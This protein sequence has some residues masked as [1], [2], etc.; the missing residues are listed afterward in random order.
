MQAEKILVLG[1]DGMDP[2]FT[3]YMLDNGEL[4]NIKKLIERGSCREDLVMLGGVPTITPPMWTTLATGANP[5][6]HGITCFWNQHPDKLD[7]LV[8][9]L[10]SRKCKAEQLWNVFAESGKKTM[11]W[12]WPGSSWPP[13][14]DSP[15]LSVVEGTQPPGIHNGI[16]SVDKQ[17]LLTASIEYD[18]IQKKGVAQGVAA[19]AGCVIEG[20]EIKENE[21]TGVT[22]VSANESVHYLFKHADGEAAAETLA[23][24]EQYSSPL[25]RPD[26]WS[27]EVPEDAKEFY[28]V[29]CNGLKQYP[30][31]ML[32]NNDGEYDTVVVYKNKKHAEA[33]LSV[34]KGEF[35]GEFIE[36]IVKADGSKV[37][38]ARQAS[39]IKM[40]KNG[41][42]IELWFS[43][44]LE[45]D[46]PPILWHP[47][48]LYQEIMDHVGFVPAT[49]SAA[50]DYPE[51]VENR[52]LPSWD[53][54]QKWQA[55]CLMYLIREKGYE[56]IFSHIHNIDAVGHHF[57]RYLKEREGHAVNAPERYQECIKE[58]YRQTDEYVGTFLPLL[59]EGWT[60]FVTSDHG[61]LSAL[62]DEMPLLGEGF[63]VNMGVMLQLGYTVLKQDTDGKYLKEIDW[64]KTTAVAPRGNHIY[65]NL[66][67]RNSTGIVDE[68][69]K[70][71]LETKIIDDLYAYRING[72]RVIKLAVRN[73]DAAI[74][75]MSGPECGDIIYFVE[76]GYNRLHGDSWATT[77]GYYHTS[78]SPIFIAA[79]QGIKKNCKTERAIHE[80]DFAPTIA[81]AAGIRMPAQCEGAPVY[82]I[83]E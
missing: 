34:K 48:N 68:K 63:G 7:T 35:V 80:V 15:N 1:V 82:Q 10:D 67:G 19:G 64:S 65:I 69:D 28:M 11:V 58:I 60:I 27:F 16:A 21:Q 83:L 6:T 45:I 20:M 12:H 78:V 52:S 75:G 38:A 57:F 70:Y 17:I 25:T 61:L 73:K 41:E 44:A 18:K 53:Y 3:K 47:Q 29:T 74:F 24:V 26:K 31:L 13:T 55:K 54:Y 40:D 56:V 50:G 32:K 72:K 9:A 37:R 76:E 5:D 81:A 42:Y 66:K 33:L 8:Y 59:D 30:C 14:S 36:D 22:D 39:I 49:N 4:P 51:L 62:E 2:R 43:T 46:V 77:Y 79:G 23:P 71:A